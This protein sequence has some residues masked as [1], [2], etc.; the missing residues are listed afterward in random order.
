MNFRCKVVGSWYKSSWG[1]IWPCSGQYANTENKIVYHLITLHAT[2]ISFIY[3][4]E[5]IGALSKLPITES[6]HIGKHHQHTTIHA[7][8]Q[9]VLR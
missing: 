3:E 2:F 1:W 8:I 5:M 6:I 7:Y 9:F 4:I